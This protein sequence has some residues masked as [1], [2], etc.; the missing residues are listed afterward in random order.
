MSLKIAILT[1]TNIDRNVRVRFSASMR[2]NAIKFRFIQGAFFTLMGLPVSGY[3]QAANL[4]L[5]RESTQ[6]SVMELP[7]AQQKSIFGQVRFESLRYM[8]EIEDEPQLTNSQFLS[9]RITAASYNRDPYSFNWAADISA[10]TFFSLRQS[11]YSVQEVYVST[12]L[13][14]SSNVSLGRKKYD[15]T[16]IDRI[17]SLGLWQPRYAIDALRPEDQGLTGLFYDYKKGYFQLL[18]FASSIYI[19]TIGPDIRE[20]NGEIKS[21]NRWYRPPSNYAGNIKIN[22]EI[23]AGNITK[24]IQQESYGLKIR[25][26][27]EEL[28]PWASVAGGRKPVNDILLQRLVRGVDYTSIAKFVVNPVVIHQDVFSADVGYQFE[29]AKFSLS[30]FEDQPDAYLPPAEFAVQKINPVKYYSAQADWNVREFIGRPVQVQLGYLRG[31]GNEVVDIE[32]TG[33]PNEI[34]LL[35]QRYRFTNAGTFKII[36]EVATLFSRPLVS[37]IGYIREFEQE[38]SILGVE[39]QYQW[40]RAWSFLVGMDSLGVDDKDEPVDGF[41]NDYRANDRFYGGASYVF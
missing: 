2:K 34:T 29:N 31:L 27:D 24:L 11:Y 18:A 19:P 21:D 17:W 7:S 28:G 4:Q 26:G 1:L 16:E 20:E 22:Y 12:P 6:K 8:S 38:G 23:D 10:G 41:I 32:S 33:E 14:E 5:P 35:E 39:F 9:G 36:G 3:G 13:S 37:K 15:W 30:Y 25:V 40:N